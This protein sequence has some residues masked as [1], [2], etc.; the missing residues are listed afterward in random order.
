MRG[1]PLVVVAIIEEEGS[2]GQQGQQEAEEAEGEGSG[3]G[4]RG[5]WLRL[6]QLRLG[7]VGT[8][9]ALKRREGTEVVGE[10]CRRG[11]RL[12]EAPSTWL[13]S[14]R[15]MVADSRSKGGR[16]GSSD[17][18]DSGEERVMAGVAPKKA[19]ADEG[20]EESSGRRG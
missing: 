9:W 6:R 12:L 14:E 19:I 8:R 4:R 7:A 11:G 1:H 18:S 10:C 2:N 13:G 17:G 5:L 20:G 3:Y 15:E 16:R